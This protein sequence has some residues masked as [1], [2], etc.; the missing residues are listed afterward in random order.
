MIRVTVQVEVVFTARRSKQHCVHVD[1]RVLVG[2]R[3]LEPQPSSCKWRTQIVDRRINFVLLMCTIG[4][5]G[6]LRSNKTSPKAQPLTT[7]ERA[8]PAEDRPKNQKWN[9]REGKVK[10]ESSGTW[11]PLQFAPTPSSPCAVPSNNQDTIE[12]KHW[13]RF[14]STLA[15]RNP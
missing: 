4:V 8:A 3:Y 7:T 10:Q 6:K 15:I 9:G 14:V 13:T 12:Q 1:P 11:K 5:L 2:S